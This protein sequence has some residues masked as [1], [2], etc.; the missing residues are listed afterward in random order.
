MRVRFES[1]SKV[2]RTALKTGRPPQFHAVRPGSTA[3]GADLRGARLTGAILQ[4]ANLRDA[5]IDAG[6]LDG[7]ILADTVLPDDPGSVREELD[8][9]FTRILER[10]DGDSD[11][12]G[13]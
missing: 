9:N 13:Q 1:S 3:S 6:Q 10:H 11:N 4:G 7:A 5:T 12:E 2:G 8:A